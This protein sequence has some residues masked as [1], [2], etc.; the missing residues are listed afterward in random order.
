MSTHLP[1]VILGEA[2]ETILEKTTLAALF[3]K[4]AKQYPLNP[5]IRFYDHTLSY[6]ALDRSSN[7]FAHW[8]SQQHIGPG[9]KVGL[10][11]PRGLELFIAQLGLIKAGVTYIPFDSNTPLERVLTILK[12][13]ETNICISQQASPESYT[14]IYPERIEDYSQSPINLAEPE[15]ISHIIFTSGSTGVPKGIPILQWQIAHL[16]LSEHKIIQVKASDKVYQGFSISF[17]MWF[18]EVWISFLVG[19]LVIVADEL[20]S[21]SFDRLDQ[22]LHHHE[23]TVLHA[24]PS[25]L[26][27]IG[28][29]IPSIRL[30]NSG[31]EACSKQVVERW[32]QPQIRFYNSYGPTETTVTATMGMLKKDDLIHVGIPLPNYAIAVVNEAF[33]PVPLG[34][35][36]E[37]VISGPGVSI[38]Y[39]QDPEKTDRVFL[40]K[41]QPLANMYGDTIYCSGDIAVIQEDG[42]LV[43]HGR[44]D[45]QVKIRGFRVELGEIE[46]KLNTIPGIQNAVVVKR[47]IHKIEH[48]VAYY[49][50]KDL[51]VDSHSLREILQGVLPYYMVPT[52]FIPVDQYPRLSSG[53][54]DRKNLPEPL[55]KPINENEHTQTTDVATSIQDV[56]KALFP[57]QDIRD[58]ADFFDDLGGHSM[59][60]ALFVNDVRERTRISDLSIADVYTYR[61]IFP[62]TEFW[63]KKAETQKTS[64]TATFKSAPWWRMLLCSVAQAFV[65]LFIFSLLAALIFVPI[66][67]YYIATY[68][69]SGFI[70][71]IFIAIS[72]FILT[73]ALVFLIILG[74]K[75]IWLHDFK[76]G[77]YPLWGYTYFKWWLLK[78]CMDLLPFEQ[79]SNT[80]LFPR[81]LQALGMKVAATAQLNR[82]EFGIAELIQIG[83]YVTISA[84][85]QLNNAT[86]K[87]GVLTLSK[88]IIEDY[89]YVG[90]GSVVNGGS[91][92]KEK[93]K[94]NDLSLLQ[95]QLTIAKNDV[96]EGSPAKLKERRHDFPEDQQ[97]PIPIWYNWLFFGLLAIIPVILFLPLLP[98]IIGLHYLDEQAEWYSFHYLIYTPVFAFFY[99]LLFLAEIVLFTSILNKDLKPGKYSIYSKVYIQ[100]WFSDQLYALL[101]FVIKPIFATIYISSVFRWLGAKVGKNTEISNASNVTHHLLEIGHESF[102]ADVATIGE[103]DI[104]GQ[105]IYLEK[106]KIGDQ[107]FIGNSAVVPQGLDLGD[108]KLFGVLS[109]PPNQ[110]KLDA[111]LSDWFGSPAMALPKR[112]IPLVFPAHL[113]FTPPFWRKVCRGIVELIRI[114]L[115]QTCILI[116]SVIFIAYG[117]DLV[118]GHWVKAILLFPFYYL[119][120]VA[121]PC[122]LLTFLSKWILI[123]RYKKTAWAMWTLPVWLSEGVTTLYESLTIPYFLHFLTGTPF[124]APFLRLLGV[125]IG[126]EVYL[127]TTDFTEFDLVR[128]GDQ[129]SLN[130]ECGPQTHLFEDR[131]M[132]LGPVDIQAGVTIG[133]GTI[134]LYDAVVGKDTSIDALSLV[135]KGDKI[136]ER[137]TWVGIPVKNS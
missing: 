45:D 93:G 98:T 83:E 76:P 132:K 70:I 58:D 107:I 36:G 108:Q 40:K 94:L 41:P 63:A 136:P 51:C 69:V 120:I 88:I 79:L 72:C 22:F 119:V 29:K 104:V 123:G 137:S 66:L 65:L 90:T 2:D 116:F 85:V 111:K 13:A 17:D 75:K 103:N 55:S 92:I 54:I 4:T 57:V 18:E 100:K 124:L 10:Y 115:P 59:L 67:S 31:G 121:I 24:V 82:F 37:L 61:K 125:K 95:E 34:W 48:L 52:F 32:D 106:T 5:A 133:S 35:A 122:F 81:A 73:P 97:I 56:L 102:V 135:M 118:T 27:I 128:I 113:T 78:K 26:S 62:L 87:S 47:T 1:S 33:E 42:W 12:A 50:M 11:L 23:I 46:A 77:D 71:P 49:Q 19:A 131:I 68:E 80:P 44:K 96:W 39:L 99:I 109:I 60:A 28:N 105:Y 9:D 64:T 110:E 89:G 117:H 74:L 114:I 134:I 101:L 14:F 20:T 7:A 112:E 6:A 91:T 86:V 15:R 30:I 8:I 84:N 130:H 43:I 126:K 127:D 21:K 53:K 16:I 129:S 25:L 38:G 3:T